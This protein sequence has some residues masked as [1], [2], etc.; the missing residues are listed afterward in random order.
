MARGEKAEVT[1]AN[2][3]AAQSGTLGGVIMGM[4]SHSESG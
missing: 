2:G 4:E 1:L 3:A